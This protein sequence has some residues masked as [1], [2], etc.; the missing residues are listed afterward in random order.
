[1]DSLG[2]V[3]I[4]GATELILD[5]FV[6]FLLLLQKAETNR[7]IKSTVYNS[8]SSRSHTI[9]ELKA[10][11]PDAKQAKFV[12]CDLAGSEKFTDGQLKDKIHQ[13]ESK[14]I[15]RSLTAL[16]RYEKLKQG[17]QDFIFSLKRS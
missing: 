9:L 3:Q 15:N 10:R 1:M 16:T 8:T 11:L 7:V 6:E 12:F 4:E 13:E 5:N 14:Y 2:E 17:H